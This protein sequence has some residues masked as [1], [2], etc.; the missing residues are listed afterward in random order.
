MVNII[1]VKANVLAVEFPYDPILVER[2]KGMPQ[3]KYNAKAKHWQFKPTLAN[4]EYAQK[5]FPEATWE[6]ETA[7]YIEDA[8]ERKAK[9]DATAQA[10]TDGA[11]DF[12]LLD[13]VPFELPPLE[14]QKKALLLG[15]D[16]PYFAYLM[17]QGTGKTKVVIDDA[18]HN[19]RQG[20][21]NGL[22]VIA[23]NSV[24]T[25]WVDPDDNFAETGLPS[26]RD[27]I[28]KHMAPDIEVNKA[29]WISSPTKHQKDLFNKARSKWGQ[30]NMLHVL[31]VN[32]EALPH[33]RI[34]DVMFEFT[35]AHQTMA[36]C[37]ESTRIKNRSAKRTKNAIKLRDNSVLARIMSGTPLI[38][39]PLDA[40][41]QFRFLDEDILGF[42]NY[43]SFQHHF[44]VMGGFNNYQT[45]YYKNLDELSEKIDAVSYR[46]LKEDCLQLPPKVY[47]KRMVE[48]TRAQAVA[49][50]DMRDLMLVNL[51]D[52]G[53]EG[54]LSASIVLTQ[55]LRLQ[56]IV[57]GY[58]PELDDAGDTIG[59]IELM[60][61]NDNPKFKEVMGIIDES[62]DQKVVV[63]CRFR[64]EI[65]GLAELLR[66]RHNEF[67]FLEFHGGIGQKERRD[68]RKDFAT[69]PRY[70]VLVANQDT[71]GIGIDE[72]KVAGV[73]I[74]LSN[75]HSTEN[76]VQSEDRQHRIGSE[77]HDKISYFDIIMQ[78]SVDE[79]IIKCLRENVN[80]SSQIMKDGYR[81][82]I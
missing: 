72:F 21:T 11:F 18:A 40:F 41:A 69:N 51:E 16:M 71:G 2:V 56:Q 80:I 61:P 79:K 1:E 73:S 45:L 14:H 57:G 20:R 54:S 8:L 42:S 78:Q 34:M 58:L 48:M 6:P 59:T 76:R 65:E 3:R 74:Y 46:V 38:K 27:E 39:S 63:W 31:I 55:M 13:G 12:S 50:N 68:I 52:L 10:K 24:K 32:V 77:V 37:D 64:A 23:P 15:R 82:W 7:G 30:P 47:Q 35:L 19:F 22:L 17:D 25:N 26:D 66:A 67:G 81:E 75:S 4:I 49:Y 9:R 33:K 29:C 44:A 60:K 62:G 5:W 43:Y 53:G 70:K 36:V 28:T